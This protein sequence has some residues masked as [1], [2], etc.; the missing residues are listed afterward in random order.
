MAQQH[1]NDPNSKKYDLSKF[2]MLIVDDFN[3][4]NEI[5]S[6]TLTEMGVK[7]VH[8]AK[9]GLEAKTLLASL[10]QSDGAFKIDALIL[11]WLMPNMGGEELLK[12]IRNHE[13]DQIRF[14][15]VIVCSAYTT[16]GFVESVRDA[17]ATE[18]LVKPVS[19]DKLAS[20]VQYVIEK[21]RPFLKAK[22]YFGPDRRRKF[23]I[24]KEGEKRKA[25]AQN[26]EEHHEQS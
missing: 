21:P 13:N 4:I 5:L 25:D 7:K 10:N 15:P 23:E 19:A 2:T 26:V 9:D 1:V 20:R 14:L 8:K 16:K 6:L 22:N 24:P 18:V 17:G 12:W 11:D 3:F